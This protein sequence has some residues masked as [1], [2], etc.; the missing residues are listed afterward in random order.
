MVSVFPTLNTIVM[1]IFISGALEYFPG[2]GLLGQ[3]V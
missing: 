1:D 2:I 3:R